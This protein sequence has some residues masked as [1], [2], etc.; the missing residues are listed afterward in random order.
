MDK[1]QKCISLET[2]KRLDALGIKVDSEWWWLSYDYP[3]HYDSKSE[4]GFN[5]NGK[6]STMDFS[7]GDKSQIEH[8]K[9]LPTITKLK[10]YR[11]YDTAELGEMLPPTI[12]D[13]TWLQY[14]S[15]TGGNN[16]FKTLS[17]TK[18]EEDKG[19]GHMLPKHIHS[20]R[21]NKYYGDEEYRMTEAEARGLMLVWLI[22]NKHIK[23][24]D[25]K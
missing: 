18:W 7:I 3:I 14:T 23:A 9:I 10:Y 13:K 11:A 25:I 6:M 4:Y 22:E 8:L 20:I 19:V 24:E 17:Y 5:P 21:F 15:S 12:G 2:A 16:L 1:T